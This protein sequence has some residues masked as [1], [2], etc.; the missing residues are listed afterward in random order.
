LEK[1]LFKIVKGYLFN[2]RFSTYN[3]FNKVTYIKI[4]ILIAFSFNIILFHFKNDYKILKD[5]LKT[6]F[7][8]IEL[9]LFIN[10]LFSL[11]KKNYYLIKL[12]VIY[13]VYTYC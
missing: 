10:K 12:K 4:N 11:A 9:I 3:N 13:L 5:L 1:A 7:I 2:L 6:L 8:A